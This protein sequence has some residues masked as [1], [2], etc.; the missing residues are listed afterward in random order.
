MFVIFL[1]AYSFIR[2]HADIGTK[3]MQNILN[4]MNCTLKQVN[5]A[6]QDMRGRGKP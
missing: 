1:M 5:E 2:G 6:L 4:E 3:Q